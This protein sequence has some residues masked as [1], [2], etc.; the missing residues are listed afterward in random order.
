MNRIINN[1][2]KKEGYSKD[3]PVGSLN[4]DANFAASRYN[5]TDVLQQ[6]LN[7]AKNKLRNRDIFLQYNISPNFNRMG[8]TS[9]LVT[10]TE[11]IDINDL[12]A[13]F[14]WDLYILE[15]TGQS[16]REFV[17]KE[18]E[19]GNIDQAIQIAANNKFI[20]TIF[21][22]DLNTLL[23][24]NKIVYD[25]IGSIELMFDIKNNPSMFFQ[26]ALNKNANYKQITDKN[27]IMQ[28]KEKLGIS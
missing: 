20:A 6:L 17:S 18:Q 10:T 3:L 21:E 27:I 7:L 4:D 14:I 26:K 23:L 28:I 5:N 11:V 12:S 16:I 8:L 9:I 22:K 2:L 19:K 24:K 15:A 13:I 1:I 25:E